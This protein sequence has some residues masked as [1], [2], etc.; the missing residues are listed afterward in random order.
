MNA[1][2]YGLACGCC[3]ERYDLVPSGTQAFLVN[4]IGAGTPTRGMSGTSEEISWSEQ[5]SSAEMMRSRMRQS[6][7]RTLHFAY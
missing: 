3:L 7:S 1:L 5:L 6:G 4:A 2:G